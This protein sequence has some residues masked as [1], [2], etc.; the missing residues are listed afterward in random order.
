[1]TYYYRCNY[2]AHAPV[3]VE[4]GLYLRGEDEKLC[5]ITVNAGVISATAQTE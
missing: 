5:R 1:M 4:G 2:N 3:T